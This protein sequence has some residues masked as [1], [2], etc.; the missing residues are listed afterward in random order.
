MANLVLLLLLALLPNVVV[1][2]CVCGHKVCPVCLATQQKHSIFAY[3]FFLTIAVYVFQL[4][5]QN[6]QNIYNLVG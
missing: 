1:V 5:L 6:A 3:S 2:I 4:L